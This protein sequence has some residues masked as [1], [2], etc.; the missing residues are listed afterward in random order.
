MEVG[1]A[2][3]SRGGGVGGGGGGWLVGKWLGLAVVVFFFERDFVFGLC[4]CGWCCRCLLFGWG[5]RR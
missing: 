5:W 2:G 1:G 3:G 4:A